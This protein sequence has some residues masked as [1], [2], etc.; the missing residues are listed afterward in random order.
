M[1][2]KPTHVKC[3]KSIVGFTVGT[4]YPIDDVPCVDPR[5]FRYI[6]PPATIVPCKQNTEQL[7]GGR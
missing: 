1:S 7:R 3:I 6:G 5:Y 4:K 2:F